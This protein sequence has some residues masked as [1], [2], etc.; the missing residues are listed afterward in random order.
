M[1]K[2]GTFNEE[3]LLI[4]FKEGNTIAFEQL[5]FEFQPSLVFF[6]NRLLGHDKI[7][8][9]EEIV[10]DVFIKLNERRNSY[11][12]FTH[13]KSSLYLSTKN[14]CLNSIEKEQVSKRRFEKFIESFNEVED[15]SLEDVIAS[16]V[17]HAEALRE[18]NREIGLLPEK[19]REIIVKFF[20]EGMNASEIAEELGISLSTVNNQKSRGISILKKRLSGPALALLFISI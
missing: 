7:L 20:D 18:L 12:T 19:C 1:T 10:Q 2:F 4:R 11:E 17:V 8:N 16:E 14:A 15:I 5:F 13:L 9:A 6:A 3:E